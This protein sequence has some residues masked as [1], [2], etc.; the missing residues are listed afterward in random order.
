MSV[1]TKAL[2]WCVGTDPLWSMSS[3]GSWMNLIIWRFI[4]MLSKQAQ[5]SSEVAKGPLRGS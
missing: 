3:R 2:L 5:S 1:R 4:D